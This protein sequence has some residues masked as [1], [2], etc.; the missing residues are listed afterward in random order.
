MDRIIHDRNCQETTRMSGWVD[1]FADNL[2]VENP[3]SMVIIPPLI[4]LIQ[5]DSCIIKLWRNEKQNMILRPM[6]L[7]SFK[8]NWSGALKRMNLMLWERKS[9]VVVVVVKTILWMQVGQKEDH[10]KDGSRW[11]RTGT[12]RKI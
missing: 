11:Q 2:F 10:Q 1:I 3:I 12:N 4:P 5:I 8:F 7:L 9:S 6:L